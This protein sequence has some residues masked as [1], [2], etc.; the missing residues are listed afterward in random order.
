V[1]Q[2]VTQSPLHYSP[3]DLPKFVFFPIRNDDND[4]SFI[5]MEDQEREKGSHELSEEELNMML[6]IRD[7]E[8]S[9]LVNEYMYMKQEWRHPPKDADKDDLL[10]KK[11]SFLRQGALNT[12]DRKEVNISKENPDGD[13]DIVYLELNTQ[14]SAHV[15]EFY[16]PWRPHC[17]NFRSEYIEIAGEMA[18]RSIGVP[19]RFHAVSCE[20]FRMICRAY[21]INGFPVIF[22]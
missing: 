21:G 9:P 10:E 14:N 7:K 2:L 16:A 13:E 5:S 1:T 12:G 6:Y 3:S 4:D 11:E 17:I 18:R 8:V 22:G 19:L 15:V 20:L